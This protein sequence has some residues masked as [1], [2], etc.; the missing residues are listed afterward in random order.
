MRLSCRLSG[1]LA[2]F[3]LLSASGI[4]AAAAS[5]PAVLVAASSPTPFSSLLQVILGL[6]VVLGAIVGLAWLF[7]RMSGG[8]LGGSNRLRVVS[9]VLVGQREK[10]VIVELEGEWLVLGVTSHS[11]NLLTKM[12][13]PPDA[14]AEVVPPGE[15]FAR[16]L[17]AAM[18]KGRQ[19]SEAV[20][21]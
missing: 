8:M 1:R 11:V 2:A 15:P 6:A 18:D 10:V 4:T 19:Q 9:G 5:A 21:K 14:G 17:K 3:C 20:N 12:D 13:R 7:R 16:W